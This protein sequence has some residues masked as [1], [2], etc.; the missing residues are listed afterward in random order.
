MP[1]PEVALER[2]AAR[3]QLVNATAAAGVQLWQQINSAELSASWNAVLSRLL[4]VVQAAQLAA[5]S[6]AD[7]Y[8]GAA[9]AAQ[10][11]STAAEGTV[12]ARAFAGVASDGRPLLSLLQEPVIVAKTMLG[13]GETIPRALASGQASLEMILRTQVA[14]AGRVADGVAATTRPR[15]G[16]TRMLNPPS[17]NRCTVLAGRFYRHNEG[18]DRHPQCDCL[19]IPTRSEEAARDEGLID[20]PKA[21]FESL[22]ESEQDKHFTKAGAQAIR[23]GADIGQVVNARRGAWG[24]ATAGPRLTAEEKRAI[25]SGRLQTVDV[26]GQP[27]FITSEGTT[28]RGLY[29]QRA[30]ARGAR[31][32]KESAEDVTRLSRTGAVRRT[33]QR[34][35]VQTPRLMPE[36]IYQLAKDREDAVRLL[37]LYGYIV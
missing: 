8:V 10:G 28:R 30:A 27:V 1:V 22:S 7:D 33:V 12:V 13:R 21:Y 14:D 23:D 3:Q 37:R 18:F 4:V 2:Y 34:Q 9:L 24:L 20:D 19:H 6:G 32:R 16:Y 5:A 29:G 25:S 36:S 31:L 15:T 11:T 35:R 26:F 17:C